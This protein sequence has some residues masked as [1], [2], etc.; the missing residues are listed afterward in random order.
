M[1]GGKILSISLID[2]V[3]YYVEAEKKTSGYFPQHPQSTTS[4]EALTSLCRKADEIYLSSVFPS[5]IYQRDLLPK[6]GRRYLPGL[7]NQQAKEK[8]GVSEAVL[9]RFKTIQEVSD[10]GVNKWQTGYC[11]I[12]ESEVLS[13]W[14]TFSSFQKKIRFVTPLSVS[15]ASMVRELE[16]PEEKFAVVWVG[17]KS[18]IMVIASADGVVHVARNVPLNLAKKHLH[19]EQPQQV[20]K[21]QDTEDEDLDV[22]ME[23]FFQETLEDEEQ[24]SGQD[25]KEAED[26]GVAQHE[27]VLT[28]SNFASELEKELG[29]TVTFF[30]QE[31]REPAP[32]LYYLLGNPNLKHIN[33]HYPLPETYE[34]LRYSLATE[35][36]RGLSSEFA[37]ENIHVLGNLFA[38]DN[39]SFIPEQ[40]AVKRKSNLLLNAAAVF[41]VA[42]I[43]LGV[44][45][46]DRLHQTRS[47]LLEQHQTH[48]QRLA[49]A[50]EQAAALQARVNKL[51][52]IEG[53]KKFYD[54]TLASKPP[55]NMFVSEL[56]M[57]VEDYVVIDKF[58]VLNGQGHVRN[59]RVQGKIRA[60][61]WEAGLVLFRDFGRKVQAAPMF[62]VT[63]INYTPK[64]VKVDPSTFDFQMDIKL[65]KTGGA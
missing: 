22:E 21:A 48:I 32:R 29:R 24:E 52:P 10:A 3:Y 19:L 15:I 63:D 54:Q 28:A 41:M 27:D 33:E 9:S 25:R 45:W 46:V 47:D 11:A 26:T 51:K 31:F 2:G 58:E 42:A 56:G 6:V 40:E 5:A 7:V 36:Q 62:E 50:Q 8:M 59:C 37:Q 20:S 1:A 12:L 13:L 4:V 16:N 17:E 38:P 14:N 64:G 43:G 23:K 39:F 57:L 65:K 55:W 35:K 49:Q 60:E 44:V 30:K 53:W 34:D 61:N 18:S